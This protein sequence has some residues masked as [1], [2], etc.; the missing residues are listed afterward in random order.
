MQLMPNHTMF[1]SKNAFQRKRRAHACVHHVGREDTSRDNK[2]TSGADT[3][4]AKL[5]EQ[6]CRPNCFSTMTQKGLSCPGNKILRGNGLVFQ[7]SLFCDGRCV[8]YLSSVYFAHTHEKE[9]TTV[10]CRATRA[11][12]VSRENAAKTTATV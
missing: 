12:R 3:D 5:Q 11:R 2:L 8:T 4:D 7:F 1:H 6:C 9:Y 10:I